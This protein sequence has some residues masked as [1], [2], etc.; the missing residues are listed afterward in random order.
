MQQLSHL[1]RAPPLPEFT[2]ANRFASQLMLRLPRRTETPRS[3]SK[4]SWIG[5]LVP[6]AL[7]GA[8]VFIQVT[9]WL[10]SLLSLRGQAGWLGQAAAWTHPASLQISWLGTAQN[11]LGNSLGV[12]AQ[13]GQEVFNNI[14]LFLQNLFG[15]FF[16]QAMVA[17]LYM[18][19]LAIWWTGQKNGNSADLVKSIRSD[20]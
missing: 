9:G 13:A 20:C 15:L 5:L 6:T 11:I 16:W 19:W 1:L 14:G 8:W 12:K 2:P 10:A 18:G 4:I 7:L 3:P 17:V